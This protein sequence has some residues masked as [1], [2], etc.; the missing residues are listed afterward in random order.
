MYTIG[1]ILIVLA[2]VLSAFIRVFGGLANFTFGNSGFIYL[3]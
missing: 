2:I 1:V 3:Y